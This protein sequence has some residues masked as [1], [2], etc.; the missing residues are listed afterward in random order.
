MNTRVR[1]GRATGEQYVFTVTHLRGKDPLALGRISVHTSED[2]PPANLATEQLVQ[3][4]LWREIF[5]TIL[6]ELD[7]SHITKSRRFHSEQQSP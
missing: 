1:E 7:G 3:K 6:H 2:L 4:L 5:A